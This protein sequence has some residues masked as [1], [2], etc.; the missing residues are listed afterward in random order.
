MNNIRQI[1]GRL[2]LRQTIVWNMFSSVFDVFQMFP[3][4]FIFVSSTKKDEICQMLCNFL[5]LNYFKS[6]FDVVHYIFWTNL[7]FILL[8]YKY[9]VVSLKKIWYFRGHERNMIVSFLLS[10]FKFTEN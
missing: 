10:A 6:V 9:Y 4:L 1:I 7:Y 3:F 5:N 8:S 2:R